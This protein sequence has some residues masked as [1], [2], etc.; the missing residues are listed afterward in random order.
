[1]H[2]DRHRDSDHE[3][4]F[5]APAWGGLGLAR[6]FVLIGAETCSAAEAL[7]Q[8]LAPHIR[9]VTIGAATC[10]KPVGFRVV[11]YGGMSYWVVTFKELN[12]RG[13]GDYYA[14]LAPTCATPDDALHPFGDPGDASLLAALH[15][16]VLGR[17]PTAGR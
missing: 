16:V 12:A 8:G 2:N 9:V 6:L 10:G 13:E 17:C 1:V 11:Q 4:A 5:S 3:Q 15:Y 7:V 14:G